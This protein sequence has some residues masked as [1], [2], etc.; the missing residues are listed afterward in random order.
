MDIKNQAF[1]I[2]ALLKDQINRYTILGLIFSITTILLAT[3]LVSIQLVGRVSIEGLLQAQLNNP[4][5]WILDLTPVLFTYWGHC[6]FYDLVQNTNSILVSERESLQNHSTNLEDKLSYISNYD[7]VSGLHNH[8]AFMQF[9][10][11]LLEEQGEDESFILCVVTLNNLKEHSCV[12]GDFNLDKLIAAFTENLKKFIHQSLNSD[13]YRISMAARLYSDEFV[14]IIKD[15]DKYTTT[16]EIISEISKALAFNALIDGVIA[17]ITVRIGATEWP[18]QC[19]S[20]ESLLNQAENSSLFAQKNNLSFVLYNPEIFIEPQQRPLIILE[21]KAAI[22]NRSLDIY[23]QPVFNFID[24]KIIGVESLVRLKSQA[25]GVLIAEDFLPLIENTVFMQDLRSIVLEKSIIK[26]SEWSKINP[27]IYVTI[28]LTAHD[29]S[30]E[31]LPD[32]VEQLLEK[33]QAKAC[34]LHLD[35]SEKACLNNQT[36]TIT[37]LRK[38]ASMGIT[39]SIDDFCSGY[40]SFV[41][42]ANFPIKEIKIDKSFVRYMMH[43]QAKMKI[44]LAIISLANIFNITV[45]AEGVENEL[46][47]QTLLQIGCTQ[48]KGY[49]FCNTIK[50]EEVTALLSRQYIEPQGIGYEKII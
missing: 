46:T 5:L 47:Y 3:S 17:N 24:N 1:Q 50:V 45:S 16:Q 30:N 31:S 7:E 22:E 35:F 29:A 20:A 15:K 33:Y 21:I 13:A 19:K 2:P 43:D 11:E 44:V 9:L 10:N 32:Q 27:D 28:N 8:R 6:F 49:F 25:F 42:L 37:V 39:I 38:L 36:K 40:S 4:A 18:N 34:G 14:I 23:Y 41:Y 12:V 48:G 26:L